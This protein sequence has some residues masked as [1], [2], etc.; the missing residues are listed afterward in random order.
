MSAPERWFEMGCRAAEVLL[1]LITRLNSISS[2][3]RTTTYSPP[4]AA[5]SERFG[6]L[7]TSCQCLLKGFKRSQL[8]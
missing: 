4:L 1:W 2:L 7:I 8:L 5:L 6:V 3:L